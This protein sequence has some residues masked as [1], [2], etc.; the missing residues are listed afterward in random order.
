MGSVVTG[1]EVPGLAPGLVQKLVFGLGVTLS[2]SHI[3][4]NTIG[5]LPDLWV[6]LFHFAG[7]GLLCSLTVP[8]RRARAGKTDASATPRQQVLSIGLGLVGIIAC[9]WLGWQEVALYER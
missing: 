3:Y 1:S 7:F 6:A 4:F 2:L 9:L 8:I 5:T